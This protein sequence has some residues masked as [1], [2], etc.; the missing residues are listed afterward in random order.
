MLLQPFIALFP[1]VAFLEKNGLLLPGHAWQRGVRVGATKRAEQPAPKK[2]VEEHE[3]DAR[4]TGGEHALALVHML[5]PRWQSKF[6]RGFPSR[7]NC[8]WPF[9]KIRGSAML[10]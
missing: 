3:D 4:H 1:E 9:G 2:E 8:P 6:H 7:R 5:V 10:N